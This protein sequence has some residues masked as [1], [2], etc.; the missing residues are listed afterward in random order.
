MVAQDRRTFGKRTRAIKQKKSS[1]AARSEP[2][3][4]RSKPEASVDR[5]AA[6]ISAALAPLIK[7]SKLRI[8]RG[9]YL[10]KRGRGRIIVTP[11][12]GG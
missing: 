11:A 7:T 10:V 2:A 4:A 9:G 5:N 12:E 6:A 8:R 3:A 1:K